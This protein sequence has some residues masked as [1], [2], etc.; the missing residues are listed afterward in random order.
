MY[1]VSDNAIILY[2]PLEILCNLFECVKVRLEIVSGLLDK[3]QHVI[4]DISAKDLCRRFLSE[5]CHQR[6]PVAH[7]KLLHRLCTDALRQV[8]SAFIKLKKTR[9]RQSLLLLLNW[10]KKMKNEI[11]KHTMQMLQT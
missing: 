1:N 7:D 9:V 6:Q 8:G 10:Y 4:L 2:L 11:K 3:Q 5:F